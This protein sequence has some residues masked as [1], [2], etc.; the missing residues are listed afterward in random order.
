MSKYNQVAMHSWTGFLS[1][2]FKYKI[3][4]K[5]EGQTCHKLAVCSRGGN[6]HKVGTP[7]TCSPCRDHVLSQVLMSMSQCTMDAWMEQ[8]PLR[9]SFCY[10][11]ARD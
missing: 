9:Q 6:A 7:W 3:G 5:S 4:I 11:G 2:G 10:F 8:A 1:Q